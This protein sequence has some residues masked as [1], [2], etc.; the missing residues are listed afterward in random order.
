M[1]AAAEGPRANSLVEG[2]RPRRRGALRL[3]L[4]RLGRQPVT[5][6]AL[7]V[8]VALL[9]VGALAHEIAPEGWDWINLSDG[10][11]NLSPTFAGGNLL[12]TDNIGRSVLVI[13]IWGLH[14]SEQ[15]AVAG[16]LL[17]VA[18]GI[19]VGA[20]AGYYGGLLDAVLMRFVD[21]VIGFPLLVVMYVAL[22]FLTPVTLWK[23]TLVFALSLWTFVA[24]V[25]R[26]RVASLRAEAFVDG[27]RAAGAS[28][29]R[30]LVRH[31][32]PNTAGA[33]VVSLTSVIGQI[34]I[35]EATVEFFGFGIV[36]A[37]TPTLGNLIAAGASTGIGAY[38]FP[39]A[40]WWVWG[41]PA[42]VLVLLLVCLN[43]V[44]DGLDAALDPRRR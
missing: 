19:A 4:R 35:V 32:L 18:I 25:V 40:G 26:A 41:G 8:L 29:L 1:N 44:G 13:T 22:A 37:I 11:R 39:A 16:A 33:V 15:V 2:L 28:D 9:V 5:L 27:A 38:N 7:A 17:A 34:A 20:V 36:S 30:I 42:I 14:F 10:G 43:V 24:R 12:G 3:V 6:A 21:F 23:A 31:L